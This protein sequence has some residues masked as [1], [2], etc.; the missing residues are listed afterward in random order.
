M[1]RNLFCK[2]YIFEWHIWY[3]V[4]FTAGWLEQGADPQVLSARAPALPLQCAHPRLPR[5][6][7]AHWSEVRGRQERDVGQPRPVSQPLGQ[8]HWEIR[9]ERWAFKGLLKPIPDA[10]VEIRRLSSHKYFIFSSSLASHNLTGHKSEGAG[11]IILMDMEVIG[12]CYW[13]RNNYVRQTSKNCS[14]SFSHS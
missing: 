12:S 13:S 6:G 10:D 5:R 1:A 2:T 14:F 8:P 9:N 4:T 11:R 3:K 7:A